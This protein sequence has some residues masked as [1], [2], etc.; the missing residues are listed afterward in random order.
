MGHIW[1]ETL[2]SNVMLTHAACS[3]YLHEHN[4]P[5]AASSTIGS[6]GALDI[7]IAIVHVVLAASAHLPR[8]FY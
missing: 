8:A 3:L 4:K 5:K 7:A 1:A 6:V 2:C